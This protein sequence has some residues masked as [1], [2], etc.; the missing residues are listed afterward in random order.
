MVVLDDM[1]DDALWF[2]TEASC[3][4]V[5]DVHGHHA[6]NVSYSDSRSGKFVSVSGRARVIRDRAQIRLLWSNR[7][8]PW[9]P[10]GAE[11]P[12][13]ALL[14][15]EVFEAELWQSPDRH[16]EIALE[17][18]GTGRSAHEVLTFA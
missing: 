5:D 14:R 17:V 15:V 13:L 8:K 6:V 1:A 9:F 7:L 16:I 3:Q 10:N 4:K 18:G 12:E 2:F 11:D